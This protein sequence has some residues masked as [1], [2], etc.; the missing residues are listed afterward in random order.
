MPLTD[1]LVTVFGGRLQQ[2]EPRVRTEL[3]RA[4]LDGAR[5]GAAGDTGPRYT[6]ADVADRH[7]AATC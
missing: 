5:S 7:R 6:M 2:L 3:L 4:A 1:R